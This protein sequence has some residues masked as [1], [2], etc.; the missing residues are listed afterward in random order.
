M[1]QKYFVTV[2]AADRAALLR[3]ADY[4]LD[5]LHQTAAVVQR[6]T[7]RLTAARGAA[8][9]AAAPQAPAVVTEDTSIEGLLTLAEV[10]KLVRDGYQVLVRESA[11]K[12]SR[13]SQ[14]MEFQDWLKAV[15]EG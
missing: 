8:G 10:G 14:T 9:A 2:V 15:T 13:A 11:A 1:A 4:E 3:L 5:L 12:Q 7:V 6:Q